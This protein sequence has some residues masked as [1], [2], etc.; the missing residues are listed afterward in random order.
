MV[1]ADIFKNDLIQNSVFAAASA[2][3][4]TKSPICMKK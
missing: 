3:L 2:G 4:D 1:H